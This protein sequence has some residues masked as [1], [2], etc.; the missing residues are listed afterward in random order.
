V[1]LNRR[2][3]IEAGSETG[4]ILLPYSKGALYRYPIR[5]T[6]EIKN[7]RRLIL[8]PIYFA[9]LLSRHKIL[10]QIKIYNDE[11]IGDILP[12][13]TFPKRAGFF[14]I[15]PSIS[16]VK[17]LMII[18]RIDK[19]TINTSRMIR[20]VKNEDNFVFSNLSLNKKTEV[21]TISRTTFAGAIGI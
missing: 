10:M 2:K 18:T 1:P 16:K 15:T 4:I 20:V 13:T 17:P 7:T 3:H 19:Q 6:E 5:R 9:F 21:K 11:E 8:P 14:T 12:I